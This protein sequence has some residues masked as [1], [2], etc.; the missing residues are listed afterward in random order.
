MSMYVDMQQRMRTEQCRTYAQCVRSSGHARACT[1]MCASMRRRGEG[2]RRRRRVR[3][4]TVALSVCVRAVRM[5]RI[6]IHGSGA[7]KPTHATHTMVVCT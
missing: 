1:C 2:L 7:H 6:S 5:P 4:L 3:Q